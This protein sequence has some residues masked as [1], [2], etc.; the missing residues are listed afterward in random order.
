MSRYALDE[1]AE[2]IKMRYW[3]IVAAKRGET[4][5]EMLGIIP[6]H[7]AARLANLIDDVMCTPETWEAGE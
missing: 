5:E 2:T 6:Q 7:P 3:L 4:V 1:T